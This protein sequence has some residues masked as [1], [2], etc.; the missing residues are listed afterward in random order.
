MSTSSA[1]EQIACSR[2][3]TFVSGG[4]GVF[5]TEDRAQVCRKCFELLDRGSAERY[6]SSIRNRGYAAPLVAIAAIFFSAY[7]FVGMLVVVIASMFSGGTLVSI[8]NDEELRRLLGAHRVPVI[9]C[10]VGAT[11]MTVGRLALLLWMRFGAL[12]S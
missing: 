12:R 8:S 2:C 5:H 1:P 4:D 3:G 6:A 7:G 11:L 10:L 9:L